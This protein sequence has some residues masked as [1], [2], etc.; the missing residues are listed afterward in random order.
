MNK[1]AAIDRL[2]LFVDKLNCSSRIALKKG[3]AIH[4]DYWA[5]SYV[6]PYR[7]CQNKLIWKINNAA[8]IL[9][10]G[11]PNKKIHPLSFMLV[12]RYTTTANKGIDIDRIMGFPS[13]V[14]DYGFFRGF[15]PAPQN[16]SNSELMD[17]DHHTNIYTQA[18]NLGLYCMNVLFNYSNV[19]SLSVVLKIAVDTA[20][21]D[22]YT[23]KP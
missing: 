11:A 21:K 8:D 15:R 10:A 18:Y 2:C 9:P 14:M 17:L 6:P 7:D 13:G 20:F 19:Y 1:Q 3:F 4:P 5:I 12:D 23:V 22:I 16:P